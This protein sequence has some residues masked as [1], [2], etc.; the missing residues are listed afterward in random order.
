MKSSDL[1]PPPYDEYDIPADDADEEE[2]PAKKSLGQLTKP[3]ENGQEKLEQEHELALVAN[4]PA[5]ESGKKEEFKSA[6]ELFARP[7]EQIAPATKVIELEASASVIKASAVLA[8]VSSDISHNLADCKLEDW[9][10]LL[11]HVGLTGM[12]ANI[13]SN[14]SLEAVSDKQIVFNY[15]AEQ[16]AVLDDV[17]KLRIQDALC[18]YFNTSV[19]VEFI[20]AVQTR[21]TP[22]QYFA[23]LKAERLVIAVAAFEDDNTVQA[24]VSHF[25]GTIDRESIFPIDT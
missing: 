25:N 17:Q 3:A 5:S 1:E 18:H 16:D 4:K 2:N 8:E 7:D 6:P 11:G 22:S 24:L 19:D 9:V 14:L 23:R 10:V 12:T 13:A 21:E 20:K 15:R